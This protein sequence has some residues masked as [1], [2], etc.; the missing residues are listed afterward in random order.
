MP[1][2]INS[3]LRAMRCMAALEPSLLGRQGLES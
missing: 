3:P 2:F 1:F